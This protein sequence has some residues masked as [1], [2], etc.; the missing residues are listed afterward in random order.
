MIS[1][2]RF[3]KLA[4][5]LDNTI[6]EPHFEKLSFRMNKKIFATFDTNLHRACI[7]LNNIEQNIYSSMDTASIYPVP[8]KWGKQG[9]ILLN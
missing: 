3:Q 2:L 1:F 4:L 8:N 5:S 9:W 7:K 6:E